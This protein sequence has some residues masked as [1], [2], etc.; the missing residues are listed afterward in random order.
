MNLAWCPHCA[1]NS[2]GLAIALS[3][4]GKFSRLRVIDSGTHFCELVGSC[5]LKPPPCFPHTKGLSFLDA[6]L[7]SRFLDFGA[8]VLQDVHGHKLERFPR[9]DVP[10]FKPFDPLGQT[11]AVNVGGRYGFVNSGFTP[12]ALAHKTWS[13]IAGS[14]AHP[15]NPLARHIDGEANVL[16]AA[17]C[18]ATRGHPAHV[19]SQPGVRAA[20]AARLKK[21]PPPPPPGAGGLP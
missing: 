8:L 18:V 12:G 4:F 7:Q 19:C 21:A 5:S 1:A 17:I 9:K 16:T 6:R 20:Y 2:W 11:P 3:R 13:Q 10:A 14:L 15:H